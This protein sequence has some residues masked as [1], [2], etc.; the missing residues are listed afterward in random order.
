MSRIITKFIT[1]DAVTNPKVADNAIETLQ[2]AND[3]VATSKIIDDAVT[4]AKLASNAVTT[5]KINADAVTDAKI[6]LGNNAYLR[7]RNAADSADVNIVKVNGSDVIEFASLPR[8]S[9]TPSSADD[10]TNKSYV[11]SL[12]GGPANDLVKL[13]VDFVYD[14]PADPTGIGTATYDGYTASVGDRVLYI[15]SHSSG[16]GIYEVTG[17]TSSV[18]AS[19]ADGISKFK[20]GTTVF[21]KNGEVYGNQRFVQRASPLSSFTDLRFVIENEEHIQSFT[22]TATDITNQYV[23][24]AFKAKPNTVQ[25]TVAGVVQWEGVDF[26]MSVVSGVSRLTFAGDLAT[27]GASELVAGDIIRVRYIKGSY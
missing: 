8:A 26:T 7:A 12:S 15:G 3:A 5:A 18:R 17:P 22:L 10:L 16:Q 20:L 19:D 9:G 2:L 24:F 6:R 4:T 23:D 27:G 11:D 1:D 21:V 14:A 13:G 25:L